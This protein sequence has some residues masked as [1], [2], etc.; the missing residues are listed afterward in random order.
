MYPPRLQNLVFPDGVTYD[1]E[2]NSYRTSKINPLFGV[3]LSLSSG[4]EEKRKGRLTNNAKSS[5]LVAGTGLEP[6][7]FGL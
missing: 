6:V 2:T 1:K 4:I 5:F 3:I 7:T